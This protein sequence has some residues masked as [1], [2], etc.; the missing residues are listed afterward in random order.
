[1]A[2]ALGYNELAK[3]G[4]TLGEKIWFRLNRDNVVELM[5]KDGG[6]GGVSPFSEDESVITIEVPGRFPWI[7]LRAADVELMRAYVAEYD[8]T[9]RVT[10]ATEGSNG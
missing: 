8:A 5:L 4:K 6:N 7:K 2:M 1:M 10:T 9:H 3:L